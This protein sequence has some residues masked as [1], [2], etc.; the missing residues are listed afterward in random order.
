MAG[1]AAHGYLCPDFTP[2]RVLPGGFFMEP[3]MGVVIPFRKRSN[4]RSDRAFWIG[5]E[6]QEAFNALA[7]AAWSPFFAWV[8]VETEPYVAPDDDCA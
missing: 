7:Y 1:I 5:P 2:P 4:P 8:E 6:A 3:R